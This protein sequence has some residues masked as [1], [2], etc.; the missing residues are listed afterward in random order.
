MTQGAVGSSVDINVQEG[1]MT[2][3]LFLDVAVCADVIVKEVIELSSPLGKS[4]Y[5][6]NVLDPAVM[7]VGCSTESLSSKSV[8]T[9]AS[10]WLPHLFFCTAGC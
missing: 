9:A 3:F 2:I 10:L 4:K 6:I 5:I 8:F 1:D 7:L